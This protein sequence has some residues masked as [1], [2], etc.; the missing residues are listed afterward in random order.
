MTSGESDYYLIG[1]KSICNVM[2]VYSWRTAK[3]VL[4]EGNIKLGK[5]RG[6]PAIRKAVL[7]ACLDKMAFFS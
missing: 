6:K 3:R 7:M 5:I 2:G 4:E 1:R